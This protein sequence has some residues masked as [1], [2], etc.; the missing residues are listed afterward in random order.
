[1]TRPDSEFDDELRA[2]LAEPSDTDL[3]PLSRAVLERIAEN[4]ATPRPMGEVLVAPLPLAGAMTGLLMVAGL[5][6]YLAAP[7]LTG[8]ELPLLLILGDLL[9]LIGGM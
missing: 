6:G 8:G 7:L 9:P 5:T 3:A 1:M 2:L 4:S